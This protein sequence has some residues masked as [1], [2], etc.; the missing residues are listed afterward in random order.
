VNKIE[1]YPKVTVYKNALPD[2]EKYLNLLK[3][4]EKEDKNHFFEDWQD[5]YGLGTMMNLPMRNRHVGYDIE[6]EDEYGLAQKEFLENLT[7]AYY[8]CTEDYVISNE[9]S[10]PSWVNNGISICKY[11]I[12]PEHR[13]MAMS[14]HTDYRGFD[15]ESPGKKFAITC[16][17]YLNDDYEGGGLSFLQEETGE[18]IDYKPEAGDIVVFPSGDPV[19]GTSHFFHGVDKVGGCEKYFIR[20]F[21]SYDHPGTEDWHK[22]VEKY[23][24]KEWEQ[25]DNKRMKEE[26]NS[27]AWHKYVVNPGEE[28]PVLSFQ[29]PFFA[30]SRW[31]IR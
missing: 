3:R 24:E 2:W 19:T 20:C 31:R 6:S 27:G 17:I 11:F 21:W 14:Y 26:I 13:D 22:N 4:S 18:V 25:M 12:S 1:I 10:L 7:E 8:K 30:K 23:G 15:S 29:T 28:D 5:W 16:T 9:I